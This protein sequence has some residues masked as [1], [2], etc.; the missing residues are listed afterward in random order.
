MP[1]CQHVVT[2]PRVGMAGMLLILHSLFTHTVNSNYFAIGVAKPPTSHQLDR[3][4]MHI[5]T[6]IK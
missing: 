2:Y 6:S 1:A 5:F 4:A 3:A